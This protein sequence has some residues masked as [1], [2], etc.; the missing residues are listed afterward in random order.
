MTILGLDASTTTIGIAY[1]KNKEIL[2]ANFLDISDKETNKEKVYYLIDYL[3]NIPYSFDKIILEAPLMG[4]GFGNTSQ[5]TIIKLIRFNA[6]LEYILSEHYNCNITL[7]NATTARKY[8]FGKARIKGVKPKEYVKT[9]LNN[10][11][12]LSKFI[13]KTKRDNIDKRME[14]VYDAIVLSMYNI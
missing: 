5:Q 14:D 7:V 1:S 6:I 9:S 10:M 4:F 2:Y 8:L 11:F 3:K 13:V 12:D